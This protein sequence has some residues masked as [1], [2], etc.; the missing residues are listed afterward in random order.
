[1]VYAN[2]LQAVSSQ[3][4]E[5]VTKEQSAARS[6][7]LAS[8]SSAARRTSSSASPET[9]KPL[10]IN[11]INSASVLEN[12]IKICMNLSELHLD[13]IVLKND[14]RGDDITVYFIE[15]LI[16][17]IFE[18]KQKRDCL[19]DVRDLTYLNSDDLEE[20]SAF[21]A[22]GESMYNKKVSIIAA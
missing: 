2:A 21:A 22:L 3:N 10:I 11:T 1:M 16:A 4:V 18:K 8:S 9:T 15:N 19:I 7:L 17:M 20:V 6:D 5:S 12:Y 13:K 14:D